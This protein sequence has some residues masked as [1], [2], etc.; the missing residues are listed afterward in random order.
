[1]MSIE[2]KVNGVPCVVINS[3]RGLQHHDFPKDFRCDYPYRG[4]EFPLGQGKPKVF[5]GM[6][7]EHD[8]NDGLMELSRRILEC[9]CDQ[10]GHATLEE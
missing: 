7:E 5:A 3:H 10:T 1:M 6:V 9:V 8:F 4:I 2:I